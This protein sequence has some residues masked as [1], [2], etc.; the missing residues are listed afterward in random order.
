MSRRKT[1][2]TRRVQVPIEPLNAIVARTRTE[3]L[4]E[5]DH[6]TLQAAVDNLARLTEE[7]EAKTTTLGR[8]RR[9]IFG[10]RS[11]STATALGQ[12][13]SD[14]PDTPTPPPNAS[15]RAQDTGAT[16]PTSIPVPRVS[17]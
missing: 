16:G 4:A 14:P 12:G 10:P 17:R 2:P 11:E 1:A 13:K 15:R 7:L 3:A 8:V 6:A 5:A 9:L